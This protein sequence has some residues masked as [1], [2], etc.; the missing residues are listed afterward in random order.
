V[1][2]CRAE[3]LRWPPTALLEAHGAGWME[4]PERQVLLL[5]AVAVEAVVV[6]SVRAE[7][8][9]WTHA[10]QTVQVMAVHRLEYSR[11]A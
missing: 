7:A 9:L 8:A 5:G 3:A 1:V 11:Q 2:P 6:A 4:P 10:V